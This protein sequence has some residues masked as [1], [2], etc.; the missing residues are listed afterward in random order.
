MGYRA[1]RRQAADGAVVPA[2]IPGV[3]KGAAKGGQEAAKR[4]LTEGAEE[5]AVAAGRRVAVKIFV[6]RAVSA[7]RTSS[8]RR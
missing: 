5:A 8:C 3:G 7:L 4:A 6:G 1:V 2:L